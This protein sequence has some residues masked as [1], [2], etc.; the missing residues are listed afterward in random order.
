MK[1][2]FVTN[3]LGVDYMSDTVFHGGKSIYGKNFFESKKM[4]Y[5][6]DDV[7]NKQNLYGRGFTL[8]G[9]LKKELYNDIPYNINELISDNFFDKIIYGS[10]WRCDDYFELVSKTYKKEDIIIID[11]EDHNVINFNYADK[12]NYFKREYYGSYSNV[13]PIN[14]GVP[15]ELILDS[16]KEKTKAVSDIIPDFNRNYQYENESDYYDE[17]SRSW[18]AIT[19]KKGGWDCLRHYEIMMNG[20][21]PLFENLEDCP[22]MTLYDLPKKEI[23]SFNKETLQKK[24]NNEL[25][26]EWMRQK[27]TTKKILEKILTK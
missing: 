7:E 1:I 8:Y 10:I 19:R 11:G 16:T 17:Y 14:F 5:M 4:W 12:G 21:I 9:K 23:I 3:G 15:E 25:V 20:C 22:S 18:Y 27:F 2:L 26:L 24:E 6:Y 13:F